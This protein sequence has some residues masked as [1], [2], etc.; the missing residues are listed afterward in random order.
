MRIIFLILTLFAILSA[1]KIKISS[2]KHNSPYENMTFNITEEKAKHLSELFDIYDN[3]INII[4]V[5]SHKYFKNLTG[6]PNHIQGVMLAN[7]NL[8]Y[9]K[10]PDLTSISEEQYTKLIHHELIHLFHNQKISCNLF[11]DWFNEGIAEYFS[12]NFKLQQKIFLSKNLLGQDLP[13]IKNLT[14]IN[15]KYNQ[16]ASLEYIISASIIEFLVINYD[17][18]IIKEILTETLKSK[19]FHEA[20][21]KVTKLREDQFNIYWKEYVKQKYDG[22]FLLDI[23]YFLWLLLPFLF[24]FSLIIKLFQNQTIINKWKYEK[25]EVEINS[26]FSD[27]EYQNP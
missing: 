4:L 7:K 16:Q 13:D 22:L 1:S 10:T 5:N 24:I 15:I 8:I 3:E 18:N 20:F 25:L 14:N 27:V 21:S 17:E 11:P 2:Y 6:L 23:Q 12:G 19:N 26:I 9:L